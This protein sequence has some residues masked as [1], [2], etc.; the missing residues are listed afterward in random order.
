MSDLSNELIQERLTMLEAVR[1]PFVTVDLTE[2]VEV[3]GGYRNQSDKCALHADH[4]NLFD[5]GPFS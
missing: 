2:G 4:T 1:M 3:L 5:R